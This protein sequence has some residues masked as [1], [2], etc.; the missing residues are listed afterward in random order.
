M[1]NPLY[2][3]RGGSWVWIE[4]YLNVSTTWPLS[5]IDVYK[6]KL[7]INTFPSSIKFEKED[8]IKIVPYKFLPFIIEGIKIYHNKKAS[9]NCVI[10]WSFNVNKLIRKLEEAG[11]KVEK[12]TRSPFI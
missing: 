6:D 2:S 8:I 11:F 7:V 1:D 9:F 10:F 3:E 4:W 12:K 5:K